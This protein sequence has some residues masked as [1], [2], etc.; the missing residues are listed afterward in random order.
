MNARLPEQPFQLD[1]NR[2]HVVRDASLGGQVPQVV[3]DVLYNGNALRLDRGDIARVQDAGLDFRQGA[4]E[5]ALD[6]ESNASVWAR[7]PLDLATGFVPAA[8]I[9]DLARVFSVT[10]KHTSL[11]ATPVIGSSATHNSASRRSSSFNSPMSVA[12]VRG[13]ASSSR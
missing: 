1:A 8:D 4:L 10:P 9:P 7:L 6:L 2:L 12:S 3:F 11:Q 5:V 13:S